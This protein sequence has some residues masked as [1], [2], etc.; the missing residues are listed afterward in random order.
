MNGGTGID[1]AD[2]SASFSGVDVNLFTDVIGGGS[3][4]SGGDAQGDQLTAIENLQGSD[5]V[6]TLTGS[7]LSND[8]DPG[9]STGGTDQVHGGIAISGRGDRLL[10]DYSSTNYA[11]NG[12]YDYTTESTHA[13]LFSGAVE[14]TGIE[15]LQIIASYTNDNL[16][17][18]GGDDILLSG[19]GND[20]VF[21]GQ[22]NNYILAD[23]G[24][25]TITHYNNAA[26]EI[27]YPQQTDESP[28]FWIDG[29]AGID[30]FS[31][32]LAHRL[33]NIVL[34]SED[35]DLETNQTQLNLQDGSYLHRIEIFQDLV[36]GAGDDHLVQGGRV[37]NQFETGIGNDIVNA[38]LGFDV[39]DGG[40]TAGGIGAQALPDDSSDLLVVDYSQ[41]DV[42]GGLISEFTKPH[43]GRY[44]RYETDGETLLDQVQFSRFEQAHITGTQNMDWIAGLEGDDELQGSSGQ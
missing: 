30:R 8:I 35:P 17:G 24:N 6:D 14:F 32:N 38:G 34:I 43:I 12:G 44:Y 29:G 40:N 26:G 13:G 10:L 27:F 31:G 4:A 25:D 28:I 37:N 11:L 20:T 1:L 39:V 22:G 7:I 42:G 15:H 9:L 2:Y 19:G 23:D 3:T 21:G 33:E 5:F 16:R 41:D 36:T 18:G